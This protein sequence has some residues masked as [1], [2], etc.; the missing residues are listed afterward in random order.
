MNTERLKAAVLNNA[1]NNINRMLDNEDLHADVYY[2]GAVKVDVS[3]CGLRDAATINYDSDGCVEDY[4]IR[5]GGIWDYCD[6]EYVKENCGK[7]I[8]AVQSI[9]FNCGSEIAFVSDMF[10]EIGKE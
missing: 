4:I 7:L 3:C 9:I 5:V 10:N 2:Y 1:K 6:A 8:T